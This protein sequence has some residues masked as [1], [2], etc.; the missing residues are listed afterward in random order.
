MPA[1]NPFLPSW[2]YIPDGEP[3]LFGDRLY[4]YGSHDRFG[5]QRYCEGDYIGWSA[6]L[7]DLSAWRCEGVIYRRD[8]H[9]EAGK[10]QL[11]APDVVQGTD[12]RYYLYYS[13]SQDRITSVAVCD[14]PAGAFR[15]LGHVR[16]AD[17]TPYGL[18]PGDTRC[19]IPACWWMTMGAFI[20]T[21]VSR[22]RAQKWLWATPDMWLNWPLIC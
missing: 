17:G 6:P 7:E 5:G 12:G 11:F 21:Q 9:P 13:M 14:K 20:C 15:F 2:E 8:Q 16:H 19:L 18:A 10:G 4:L 22:P 1:F 3:R